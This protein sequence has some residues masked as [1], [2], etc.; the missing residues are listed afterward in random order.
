[1][2]SE[3]SLLQQAQD[4]KAAGNAAFSKSDIP[5]A[6][7]QY[8]QG[9]VACDRLVAPP[10]TLKASLLSNRA[11]CHLKVTPVP[12]LQP[13]IDDCTTALN[14]KDL[15]DANL[16]QK[17][18]YRRAKARFMLANDPTAVRSSSSAADTHAALQEAA[19][20]LLNLLQIDPTNK[21]ANQLLQTVR[22]QHKL[23][24]K[25]TTPVSQTLQSIRDCKDLT[26]DKDS[27]KLHQELKRLISLLDNDLTNAAAEL[28]RVDGA[29]AMLLQL[30]AT[31]STSA[32]TTSDTSASTGIV[33]VDAADKT[34]VLALQCLR[35][36][37][38]LPA[39]CRKYLVPVQ[40]N[41]LSIVEAVAPNNHVDVLVT[42]LSILVRLILHADRDDP[43]IDIEQGATLLDNT[44][45]LNILTICWKTCTDDKTVLRASL[46]VLSTWT[47]SKDRDATIRS[48]LHI[49][50]ISDSTVAQPLTQQEIR[51]FTPQELSVYR[52]RKGDQATRDEAWAFE[53]AAR[54]CLGAGGNS[55]CDC[56]LD[57]F[58]RAAVACQDHV[59]RREMT[60]VLGRLLGCLGEDD[61]TS[62]KDAVKAILASPDSNT[63]SSSNK[64]D[65]DGGVIIEEIYNQDG[66]EKAMEEEVVEPLEK[67]MAR[68]VVTAALLLSRKEVGAWALSFGWETSGDDLPTMVKSG[69]AR[70]MCLVSEVISGAATVESVRHIVSNMVNSGDLEK[71]MS[72]DDR[73]IRS[74]AAS[75]VA[76]LGLSDKQTDEG[77]IMGLLIAACSLLE[78]EGDEKP[79]D[80]SDKFRHFSSFSTSS[81]E[82]AIEMINYLISNT[83][84]KEELAAGFSPGMDS[85]YTSLERLVKVAD[86]PNVGETLTAYGLATIFQNMAVTNHILRK[87]TFDGKEVTME[88][89]DE[90]QKIGKSEE[91][92]DL[93]EKA[94][95]PDTQE[96][97]D[98]RIRK[99]ASANVPRTLVVIMEG[100]SEHTLEQSLLGLQRMACEPSVRGKMIQQGVLSACIKQEKSESPTETDTMKKVIRQARHTIAKMLVTTNPSLLTS[101]QRLGSIKSLI[102][103]IRDH[104]ASDLEQFEA[105]L[106]LTNLASSGEDA[107]NRI[108]S[109]R[110]IPSL[111]FAMFSD[112]EMVRRSATEAMC[113]LVPHEAMMKHLAEQE[114]LRLWLAFGTEYENNYECA[115]AASGCLAMASQDEAIAVEMV[116]LAKFKTEMTMLLESGRLEIMHRAFVIVL[117]LVSHGGAC[118]EKVI[119][120]GLVD[121]CVAYVDSF[122]K[123]ET[124]ELE[125]SEEERALLPVTVEIAKK[126]ISVCA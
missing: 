7:S 77:E 14:L 62:M 48:A 107:R 45:I 61:D 85:A 100:A 83:T 50:G 101:A 95:D 68:A 119:S 28:G 112:H 121:F 105:L 94:M 123:N 12:S 114:H 76:K 66:E 106:A 87:E 58:L 43:A 4:F 27:K 73:D 91:E 20:D 52:K 92:K 53:R 41:L 65:T 74:G 42:V 64:E 31:S 57:I 39:F 15:G 124:N 34:A 98:E 40:A 60:V 90:M 104:K 59:V 63:T 26:T 122:V 22:V 79:P 115:R 5:G 99:M 33:V 86:L 69:D 2:P 30:A 88:A 78:D 126:I 25:A 44:V 9:L 108:V 71:L 17:V 67:L 18:L 82:R 36:A 89:Y 49:V 46:D 19:K 55:D 51:A 120:E 113:N 97:C 81:V 84:V 117:S 38:A 75:A 11:M 103:L 6:I 116:Q 56:G 23:T 1:M 16:R 54:F 72:S 10:V 32:S 37:S 80:Q 3:E 111:H 110:G 70:A 93:L 24:A 35:T 118:K 13:C 21:E 109:E 29:V 47:A 8:S 96:L 102:Q 125:F